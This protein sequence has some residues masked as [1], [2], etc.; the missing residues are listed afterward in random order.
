MKSFDSLSMLDVV[1]SSS[2]VEDLE[3]AA[4]TLLEETR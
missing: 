2:K 3:A 1:F 4:R